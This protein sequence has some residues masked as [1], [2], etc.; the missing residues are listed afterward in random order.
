MSL[1]IVPEV[2]DRRLN[3]AIPLPLVAPREIALQ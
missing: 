2:I 1:R 3:T